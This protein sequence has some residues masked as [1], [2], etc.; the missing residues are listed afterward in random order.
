[1]NRD[2]IS[3][4]A[5]G[6][7]SAILGSRNLGFARD[8]LMAKYFGTG[9]TAQAFFAAFRIPNLCAGSSAKGR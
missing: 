6:I 5:G 7:G 3:R 1:M 9:M 2:K 8:V 4:S